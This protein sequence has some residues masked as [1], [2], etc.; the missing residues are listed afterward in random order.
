MG[1]VFLGYGEDLVQKDRELIVAKGD[2]DNLPNAQLHCPFR[3]YTR[4]GYGKYYSLL[5]GHE[6]EDESL[7]DRLVK[8][9]I[10]DAN[11]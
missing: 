3:L 11:Y 5:A 2:L 10:R 4:V 9:W 8:F 1:N 7:E 6:L